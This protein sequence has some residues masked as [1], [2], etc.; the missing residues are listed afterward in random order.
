MVMA[1]FTQVAVPPAP[2]QVA[3]VRQGSAAP[4]LHLPAVQ[5]FAAV[6][7]Q[8]LQ[9]APQRAM[10]VE[11][12]VATQGPAIPFVHVLLPKPQPPPLDSTPEQS[13]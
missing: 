1:V 8:L 4:H 9:V 10:S 6:T 5:L 12:V 3:P 7:S 11:G 13:T 2:Q